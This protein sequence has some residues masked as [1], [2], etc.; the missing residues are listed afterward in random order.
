MA[1]YFVYIREAHA[2]DEWQ[3]DDN[4]KEDVVIAQPKNEAERKGAALSCSARLKLS[5]PVLTDRI[6]NR[7]DALY[8]AWPERLFVIGRDGD[9]AARFA[10]TTT[11]DD[12]ALIAAI[13]AELAKEP[14]E[15]A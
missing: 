15:A 3:M 1:F 13:E 11:P 4:I 6:D 8:A 10:P 12:P 14:A 2:S 9:I 7:V 5:M